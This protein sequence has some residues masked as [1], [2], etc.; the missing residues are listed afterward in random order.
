MIDQNNTPI[1]ENFESFANITRLTLSDRGWK[2][3][4]SK[5]TEYDQNY[6]DYVR[7]HV[8]ALLDIFSTPEADF[9]PGS[10]KVS[11]LQLLFEG[12]YGLHIYMAWGTWA[13]GYFD[14]FSALV[15]TFNTN[16]YKDSIAHEFGDDVDD[17]ELEAMIELTNRSLCHH[18][19]SDDDLPF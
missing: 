15:R 4:F 6:L 14:N 2:A 7:E 19:E 5:W 16:L 18:E 17:P 10:E 1:A 3:R 11:E 9:M 12:L 13:E 8:Y